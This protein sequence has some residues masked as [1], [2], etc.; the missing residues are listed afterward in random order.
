MR[1]VANAASYLSANKPANPLNALLG[2]STPKQALEFWLKK[3][4]A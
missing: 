4:D 3:A 1:R 2:L